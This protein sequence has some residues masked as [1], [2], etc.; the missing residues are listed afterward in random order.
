MA[1][2]EQRLP[3]G[4]PVARRDVSKCRCGHPAETQSVLV[5]DVADRERGLPTGPGKLEVGR[6]LLQSASGS[7]PVQLDSGQS[8]V[9]PANPAEFHDHESARRRR[10]GK[11][12]DRAA[13]VGLNHGLV[14]ELGLPIGDGSSDFA[15][16][17]DNHD[18]GP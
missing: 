3:V 9:H 8:A 10:S 14:D 1:Q 5:T 6:S 17:D 12:A 2:I 13:V 16:P 4:M 15:R 7:Q 18:L 11:R